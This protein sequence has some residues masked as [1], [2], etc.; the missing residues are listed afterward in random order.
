MKRSISMTE[1]YEK[2]TPKVK[3]LSDGQSVFLDF[4]RGSSAMV[5]FL[6]HLLRMDFD[7]RN[8]IDIWPFQRLAVV[9]FFWLSGV[10]IVYHSLTRKDY[11]AGAFFIDRFSRIYIIFIGAVFV[12]IFVQYYTAGNLGS[13]PLKEIIANVLML[14]HTPFSKISSMLPEQIPRLFGNSPFWSLII[15]WWLYML[16]MVIFFFGR[17]ASKIRLILAIIAIPAVTVVGYFVYKEFIGLMWFWGALSALL[18]VKLQTGNEPFLNG[19]QINKYICC[20]IALL[21]L[22]GI[23]VRF[24]ILS[25][26][27]RVFMLDMQLGIF[28]ATLLCSLLFLC[29]DI[30]F[31]NWFGRLSKF[32]AFISYTLFLTHLP[33][34][35][36]YTFLLTK[37]L[38]SGSFYHT[39]LVI[40]LTFFTG[41]GLA[42]LLENRHYSLRKVLKKRLL[43]KG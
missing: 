18:L 20:I 15:E 37:E 42:L 24:T 22:I 25:K 3:T 32:L 26:T 8:F 21:A 12:T 7:L 2:T 34:A 19:R 36:F 41:V 13:N 4:V 23:L 6:G 1:N 27:G 43:K 30:N 11:T 35:K 10:V 16:W 5:V 28:V 17:S 39:L 29:R 38:P 9:V 33:V 14:A 40:L 31:P